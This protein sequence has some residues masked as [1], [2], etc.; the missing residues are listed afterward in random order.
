MNHL[1]VTAL[2]ALCSL[3][4]V[5]PADALVMCV[6]KKDG[7]ED[8]KPG[9]AIR[10]RESCRKAEKQ[11][12]ISLESDGTVRITG[13]N[14]QIVSG[15]GE[16]GGPVN[17]TGNLIVGYNE[18]SSGI[19]ESRTGSHNLVVGARHAY[20]SYGGFVAGIGN[21]ITGPF[22]SVTGGSS[23]EA[24][25]EASW[26]GGGSANSASG[27]WASAAGGFGGYAEGRLSLAAG[28]RS[29]RAQARESTVVGGLENQAEGL[30][31]TTC[32]GVSN[33]ARGEVEC[34]R[35]FPGQ[36]CIAEANG[37][38]VMGGFRNV[39]DGFAATVVG[40]AENTAAA[41]LAT[42]GGGRENTASG[43]S[44][45][46]SGGEGRSAASASSWAAGSLFEAN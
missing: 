20:P 4:V 46:V 37:A 23:N 18:S 26:V 14:L 36:G 34:I 15:S 21:N 25:G 13:A 24:S 7:S 9:S 44:A 1:T 43:D 22:S 39:A 19:P 3:A 28:G 31:S 45:A 30:R 33:I 40:G 42:V 2:L 32:G 6:R 38:V 12:P 11:L 16:T 8:I 5:L 29:N 41:R 17:G 35:L 27:S 10:L